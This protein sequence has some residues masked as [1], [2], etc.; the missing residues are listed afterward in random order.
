MHRGA[1]EA[2]ALYRLLTTEGGRVP[3]GHTEGS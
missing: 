3:A 1:E 2:H